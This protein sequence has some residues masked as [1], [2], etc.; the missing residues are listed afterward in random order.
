MPNVTEQKWYISAD[1]LIVC[2]D[3]VLIAECVTPEIAEAIVSAHNIILMSM[4]ISQNLTLER[5]E[6]GG[7]VIDLNTDLEALGREFGE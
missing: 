3:G 7:I 6:E 5:K 2:E 1:R 4:V